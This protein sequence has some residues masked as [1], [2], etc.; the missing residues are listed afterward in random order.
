[1]EVTRKLV[2]EDN[3]LFN[4]GEPRH[5]HQ[6]GGPP[7]SERQEDPAALRRL[8]RLDVGPAARVSLDH[9]LPAQLPDRSAHLFALY[10]GEPSARQDRGALSGRRFRQGLRQGPEGRPR[11]QGSDRGRGGV[12]GD[13][14]QHRGPDGQAQGLG[15]RHLHAIHHTEI[16]HHGDQAK[17]RSRLEAGAF[18][19][20]GSNWCRP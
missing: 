12:Q 17:C 11:R 10:P 7:R 14:H 20:L 15:R 3:V 13:R 18:S 4:P 8:G 6:P 19:R 2:E 16:R 9:G 1:M 5:Q